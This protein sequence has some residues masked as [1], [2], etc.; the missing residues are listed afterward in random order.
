MAASSL[1]LWSAMVSKRGI[2]KVP[3]ISNGAK[4]G[5]GFACQWEKMP[6]TPAHDAKE[7]K[8]S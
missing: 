1:I 8:Q 7:R 5:N 2:L 4:A 6:P 3:T